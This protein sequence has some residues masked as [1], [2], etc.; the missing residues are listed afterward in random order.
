MLPT[1]G[2]RL[3]I[4]EGSARI[5]PLACVFSLPYVIS[6]RNSLSNRFVANSHKTKDRHP[7]YPKLQL[8][9]CAESPCF[10]FYREE[11]AR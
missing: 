7:F 11:R 5:H 6:T 9:Q 8:W 4:A 2:T 10:A 3:A 1:V